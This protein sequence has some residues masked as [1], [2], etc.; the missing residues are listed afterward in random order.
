MEEKQVTRLLLRL[1]IT[2]DRK[3]FRYLTDAI[4]IWNSAWPD[5]PSVTKELYPLIA[6]K[7]ETS[8]KAVERNIRSALDALGARV[9][10]D[11]AAEILGVDI[12]AFPEGFTNSQF[13]ALC[14]L[15]LKGGQNG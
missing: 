6:E 5:A 10:W 13:I 12:E 15:K 14:A 1:G 7:Y 8:V 9:S 2:P 11:R 3:G 4:R